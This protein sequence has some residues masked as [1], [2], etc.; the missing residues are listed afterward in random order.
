MKLNLIFIFVSD[1]GAIIKFLWRSD[2]VFV[3]EHTNIQKTLRFMVRIVC[4]F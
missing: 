4:E 3:Q 2:V 1:A